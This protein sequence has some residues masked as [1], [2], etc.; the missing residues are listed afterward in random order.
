MGLA[1]ST[2]CIDE[3]MSLSFIY[4]VVHRPSTNVNS[5]HALV[6]ADVLFRLIK[7]GFTKS[8]LQDLAIVVKTEQ[9]SH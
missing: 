6:F 3:L 5:R 8:Y 9:S 2:A 1:S 7:T 4:F